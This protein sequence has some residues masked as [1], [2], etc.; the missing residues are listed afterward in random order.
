MGRPLLNYWSFDTPND[1]LEK[2]GTGTAIAWAFN[3][4]GHFLT[5]TRWNRTLMRVR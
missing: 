2:K 3:V 5:G 1:L 4:A